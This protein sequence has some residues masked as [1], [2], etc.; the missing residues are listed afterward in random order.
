M[1]EL[2]NHVAAQLKHV[3]AVL[4]LPEIPQKPF[5]DPFAA[6]KKNAA[7]ELAEKN[8]DPKTGKKKF[9]FDIDDDKIT[10]KILDEDS[11][12]KVEEKT[13]KSGKKK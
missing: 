2:N 1:S 11:S 10:D 5:E 12:V 3:E 9:S 13:D 6:F 8:I 7:I 4:T